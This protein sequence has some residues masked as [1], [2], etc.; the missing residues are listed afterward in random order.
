MALDYYGEWRYTFYLAGLPMLLGGLVLS[1]HCF[2]SNPLLYYRDR[3]RQYLVVRDIER[4]D[5]FVFQRIT[6]L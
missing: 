5:E 1:L 3:N 6:V 4:N 2:V